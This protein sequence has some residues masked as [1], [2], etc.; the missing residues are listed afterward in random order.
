MGAMLKRFKPLRSLRWKMMLRT[1]AAMVLLVLTIG[2][3]MIFQV[4]VMEYRNAVESNQILTQ[5]MSDHFNG[6]S[7]A[8]I[9]QIDFVTLD[10]EIQD[11][12][13]RMESVRGA[14]SADEHSVNI[15]ELRSVITLRSIV[16]DEISGVYLY[17]RNGNLI[18]KWEKTP[19][20]AGVYKLPNA[21]DI[22]RYLPD[23][24]VSCEF[25]DGHLVYHRSVR[26]L[27]EWETVAYIS[28]LYDEDA[29]K[30]M[31]EIIAE[32]ETRF[33]GLYDS[34]N[35]V[36]VS[37]DHHDNAAY[38]RA[39]RGAELSHLSDGVMID[40]EGVGEMLLCGNAVMNDGWYFLSA[41]RRD[42]IFEMHYLFLLMIAAFAMIAVLGV[43]FVTLL[44][45]KIVMEPIEKIMAVVHKVQNEDYDIALDVKTGDEIELLA[46]Q[47][48]VM[49]EKINELVNQNLKA[50]LAYREMQLSQLQHQIKPHFLYNTLECIN[51]LSQLDRKDDVRVVT[52][53]FARLMKTKMSDRRFT[54]VREELACVEDFLQIYKVMQGED[55]EYS[56]RMDAACADC[57][58]PSLM[59]QP[60][61][62]NA[63]LHGIVPSARKGACTVEVCMEEGLLHISV[64]DD[65]VGFLPDPWAA[66]NAYLAGEATPEQKELLG[67]GMKNV[68]DRI[69]FVYGARGRIILLSD[70]EWGTTF[71]F[72]L[73]GE[74]S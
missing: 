58:I 43:L 60:I 24:S 17:D 14:H 25:I 55:L 46:E 31:L 8:F 28:F 65:G 27:E 19:N 74:P 71:D 72:F 69:R 7:E 5:A 4:S 59:I 41:V 70:R 54:T 34:G 63:V 26:T 22:N 45:K 20:R 32:D 10:G 21:T 62:E 53:A 51:A 44:N 47:F 3:A 35:D 6:N 13:K 18:T 52:G 67:I 50:N 11:R 40:V 61:V 38:R 1:T 73:P 57:A 49:A 42:D 66:A 2:V 64:S 16:M 36:L 48:N 9:H 29:L 68:I 30:R 56:I 23:G 12:V 33:L 37:T 15:N 39:L